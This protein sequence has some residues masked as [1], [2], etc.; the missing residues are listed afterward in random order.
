VIEA[1]AP[2]VGG[3]VGVTSGARLAFRRVLA[4]NGD[5]LRLRADV[6]PFEDTW[7]GPIVGCVR[8]RAI[9]RLVAIAP[10]AVTRASWAAALA[11]AHAAAAKR[12]AKPSRPAS[13][14]TRELERAEWAKVRAFWRA[15]CGEAL[16]V[17]AQENQRAIGLFHGGELVGANIHLVLGATSYSAYTLV[18][19]RY[20]GLGGGVAMIEHALGLAR[21]LGLEGVY[22][23]V[24]VRNLPSLRA[25][26]RAGF[27]RKGYWSDA[28]DPLAAAERQWIVLEHD[29]SRVSAP[30]R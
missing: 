12:R 20:R 29:L 5:T 26:E 8:T 16:P 6:A 23:H 14:H 10:E 28:S 22:V 18:D 30:E 2:R 15:A 7:R 1:G 25:Y 27:A 19:R 24:N 11:L 3:A 9:D 21:R 4:V 17:A 13:F